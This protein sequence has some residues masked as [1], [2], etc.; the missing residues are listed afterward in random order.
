MPKPYYTTAEIARMTHV[1]ATTVADW[2]DSGKLKAYRTGGGHRRVGPEDL[3]V[4]F[5]NQNIPLPDTLFSGHPSILIIDDDEDFAVLLKERLE[6][7]NMR[8]TIATSGFEG[9]YK[10]GQLHPDVVILD[11]M[12]PGMNGDEVCEEIK[13]TEELKDTYVIAITAY[14][15]EDL[16][17]RVMTKGADAFMKKPAKSGDFEDL[18]ELIVKHTGSPAAA[19]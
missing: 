12:M 18:M 17:H 1:S 3:R 10:L 6:P 2:I 19:R 5:R 14:E 13:T 9:I 16:K 7:R 4:F 8:V 11:M 15:G